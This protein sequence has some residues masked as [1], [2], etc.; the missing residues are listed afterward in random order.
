MNSSDEDLEANNT[1]NNSEGSEGSSE[2]DL[3]LIENIQVKDLNLKIHK[4]EFICVIGEVGSG[5]S[6]LISA[7]LGDMIYLDQNMI[8]QYSEDL[9]NTELRRKINQESMDAHKGLIKVGGSISY[10]QQIPWIQ[11][12]TIRDNILFGLNLNED[13]YNRT[14]EICQLASDLEM[15]PGGDLTE[16]GE[17]GINLSG[18]QK[19][20]ISLARAVYANKDIILMD[21]PISALDSNVKKKIFDQVFMKEMKYKTRVLVTHAVDFIDRVDKIII[22][23]NGRIKYMGTYEELQHS[24]EIKHII[25]TLAHSSIENEDTKD[26]K[27]DED[28]DENGTKERS[29]SFLNDSGSQITSEENEEDIEVGWD[30]Y[31]T[32][33]LSNGTWI[34]YVLLIPMFV[35]YS[36]L[37]VY[38][39]INIGKWV[40]NSGDRDKFWYYFWRILLHPIGYGS[41]MVTI[42]LMITMSTVRTSK[43]VH[44]KMLTKIMNAPINLYFD[45]T[46]SGRILNRFSKDI[47]KV[48]DRIGQ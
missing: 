47:N 5:K 33:F 40:E 41:I 42:F 30:V 18:G 36:Y 48:D 23:E 15:L 3:K 22:M 1:T 16:I 28:K 38:N 14:I 25:Q 26:E 12:K 24:D 39:T 4:G 32:F 2:H 46:P 11:N 45:R 9:M 17:K 21:D 27:E 44:S 37:I 19:A 31:A 7:I 35:A 43:I 29:R 13:R 20:R 8:D 10:V 34:V 6:S